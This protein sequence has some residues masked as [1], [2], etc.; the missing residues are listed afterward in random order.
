MDRLGLM[1]TYVR[2][3][4]SRSFSAAARHLNVGQSAV[5]KSV[6]QLEE[7]LGVRLLMRSTRGHLVPTEAGQS[8]YER[9]RRAIE[10]AREAECAANGAGARLS[11]RLRVSSDITFAR[12]HL[13]PRLAPFLTAHPELSIDL[14]QDDRPVDLIEE[15]ADIGLRFG[16]LL[17]P[18]LTGR[19]VA[20]TKRLVLGTADYFDR[21]GVPTT[22]AELGGHEAVIYTRDRGGGSAWIFRKDDSETSVTLSG[23]LHLSAAEGVRAAVL[24]SMGLAIG[25]QWVFAPEL[26]CGAVHAVLAEW[27]LPETELWVV[28]PHGR[29]ATASARAFA[30]F[31]ESNSIPDRNN[32]YCVGPLS[33]FAAAA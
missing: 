29:M 30:A 3:L 28:F 18:S 2:V 10:E 7:R 21:T 1:E 5:S 20:S 32:E 9:A 11:G 33:E 16:P 31:V 12:L 6:A 14:L 19:K 23:R 27:T 24:N 8:Y 25:S 22:P 17:D 13:I 15:G 26:A 4:E